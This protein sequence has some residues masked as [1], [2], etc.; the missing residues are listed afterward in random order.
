MTA[1]VTVEDLLGGKQV[2]RVEPRTPLQWVTVI[3]DGIPS[4]AVDAL[5]RTL[6]VPQSELA[7]SLGIPDRTLARRKKEGRLTSEES[8]K[9]VRLARVIERSEEVFEDLDAALDWLKS[10]NVSLAGAT[11]LSLL[12]T[13]IGGESV[14]DTL[15]RIEHGV[16]A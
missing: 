2:L 12:D 3:R 11:P 13:D 7:S 16:F 8:A 9:L 4:A 6:R 10:P 15:G 5:T 1:A 14:M